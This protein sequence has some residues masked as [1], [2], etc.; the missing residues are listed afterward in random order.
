MFPSEVRNVSV[1]IS[2]CVDRSQARN[3]RFVQSCGYWLWGSLHRL[4]LSWAGVFSDA[5]WLYTYAERYA[6]R[7]TVTPCGEKWVTRHNVSPRIRGDLGP[8]RLHASPA[9]LPTNTNREKGDYLCKN[10]EMGTVYSTAFTPCLW[11]ALTNGLQSRWEDHE[12]TGKNIPMGHFISWLFVTFSHCRASI[13]S[14]SYCS[15]PI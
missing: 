1:A 12:I 2:T 4:S 14:Y 8:S 6:E 11:P 7:C 15:Q 3:G 10:L 9:E 5:K 13:V